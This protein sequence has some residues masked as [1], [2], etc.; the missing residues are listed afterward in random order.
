[1]SSTTDIELDEATVA[2]L[3][4]E[5]E[6][7][8]REGMDKK[9]AREIVWLD[10]LDELNEAPAVAPAQPEPAPL[11]TPIPEPPPVT[12]RPPASPEGHFFT[13]ERLARNR[14]QI[15]HV[16]QFLASRRTM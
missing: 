5:T 8:V 2:R 11:A 4:E 10:Y 6:L 12:K 7:L 13:P 3:R 14:Q 16:K 1:M 9:K 15:Q